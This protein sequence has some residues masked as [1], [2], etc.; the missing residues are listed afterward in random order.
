MLYT[1]CCILNAVYRILYILCLQSTVS[2]RLQ[3][4][5]NN[6]AVDTVDTVDADLPFY[7]SFLL[8]FYRPVILL[9]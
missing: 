7:P 3:I 6:D 2:T 8:P 9:S 4:S 5:I 1:K